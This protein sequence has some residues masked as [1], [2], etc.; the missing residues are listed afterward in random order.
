MADTKISGLTE[1]TTPAL[2]DKLP[3]VDG[4]STKNVK[5]QNLLYLPSG[6]D[7]TVT[8]AVTT[9]GFAALNMLAN[10]IKN[11]LGTLGHWY[12]AITGTPSASTYLCGD[13]SWKTPATI[14][15]NLIAHTTDSSAPTGF[16]EFTAGRGRFLV[17]T[18]SGGTN[19]GT[20]GTALTN[21]QNKTHSHTVQ[22]I[23]SFA[24]T[25][26]RAG[27]MYTSPYTVPDD[28][29]VPTNTASTGDFVPFIQQL[30]IIKT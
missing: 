6:I 27:L 1:T 22:C 5:R 10:Q 17:G 7:D 18:P 20:V 3:I 11:L 24:N 4:G 28:G 13:G 19:G 2:T 12:S 21:L 14:P 23:G 8:P 25:A 16:S 29:Q 15:A 30:G 26:G 9:D